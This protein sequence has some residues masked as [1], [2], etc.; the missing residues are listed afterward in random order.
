MLF[1]QDSVC[2]IDKNSI[3]KIL[4]FGIN[5]K[6]QYKRPFVIN[7]KSLTDTLTFY[8]NNNDSNIE[9][10]EI[11]HLKNNRIAIYKKNQPENSSLI[12]WQPRIK[13]SYKHNVPD[14]FFCIN[15]IRICGGEELNGYLEVY[16]ENN[17]FELL[18]MSFIRSVE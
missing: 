11:F 17:K 8:F 13:K 18:G 1:G 10:G 6:D 5:H 9:D 12:F 7:C 3:G 16:C 2:N 14:D 15:F 4:D